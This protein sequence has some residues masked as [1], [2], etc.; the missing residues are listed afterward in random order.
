[1][2]LIWC[3]HYF[4]DKKTPDKALPIGS[5]LFSKYQLSY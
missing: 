3:L 2:I 5:H 4:R 1:M